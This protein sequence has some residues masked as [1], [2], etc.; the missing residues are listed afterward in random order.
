MIT[1]KK[2]N[3]TVSTIVPEIISGRLKGYCCANRKKMKITA[4]PEIILYFHAVSVVSNNRGFVCRSATR[5][6]TLTPL[7]LSRSRSSACSEKKAAS[8]ADAID[9]RR[10][11]RAA[12]RMYRTPGSR[13]INRSV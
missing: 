6:S 5:C 1:P 7:F 10:T 13:E 12:R 4:D 8:V 2:A 11:R 9:V 3:E